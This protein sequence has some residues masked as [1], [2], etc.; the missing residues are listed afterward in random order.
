MHMKISCRICLPFG[1]LFGPNIAINF[2]KQ[3]IIDLITG[4]PPICR[5]FCICVWWYWEIA[6]VTVEIL[7]IIRQLCSICR[8]CQSHTANSKSKHQSKRYYNTQFL[9]W[10]V[11]AHM[12]PCHQ[13][14]RL[15]FG[16]NTQIITTVYK[17][18]VWCVFWLE[19][20]FL[21]LFW[22]I[23]MFT[24]SWYRYVSHRILST[25]LQHN[26]MAVCKQWPICFLILCGFFQSSSQTYLDFCTTQIFSIFPFF[27]YNPKVK[28]ILLVE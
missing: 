7:P 10:L 9:G 6:F 26:Y 19:F 3:L 8:Y 5:H 22:I 2:Y 20:F 11:N 1:F 17:F 13:L 27:C 14:L 28:K 4:P 15:L 12:M 23:T 21:H 25:L 16:R 24:I 18:A